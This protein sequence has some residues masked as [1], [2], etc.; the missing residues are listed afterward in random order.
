VRKS[1]AAERRSAYA[2]PVL[3]WIYF[4]PFRRQSGV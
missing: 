2:G 3:H 1:I 4:T